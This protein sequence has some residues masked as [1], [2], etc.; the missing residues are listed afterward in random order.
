MIYLKALLLSLIQSVA[1]FLPISSSAHLILISNYIQFDET[2]KII[3]N[4]FIQ[5]AS[6]LAI[7]CFFWKNHI[8]FVILRKL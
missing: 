5:F 3:F 8:F 1:E 2:N 4:I 7:I 6:T